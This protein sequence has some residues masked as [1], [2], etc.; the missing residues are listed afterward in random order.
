MKRFLILSFL[1]LLIPT[2]VYGA[3]IVRT[4][5][6]VMISPEQTVEDD[7]YALGENVAIS[8]E[9]KGDVLLA[10]GDITLNGQAGADTLILAGL[11]DIHGQVA[12]DARIV[13]GEVTIAGEILGDLV[14]V[15]SS[16][17]VLPT[18]KIDGDIMF[19]GSKA[20]ISG[21]VGGDIYGFID[22]V[23]VDAKVLGGIEV[24]TSGLVLGDQADIGAGI[25]YT[26][27][28]NLTR[29]QNAKVANEIVRNDPVA[30]AESDNF[31]KSFLIFF[32]ITAFASLVVHLIFNRYT[33]NIVLYARNHTLRSVL[34]GFGIMFLAPIASLILLISTLG[35]IL[36]LILMFVYASLV[37]LSLVMMGI[38]T[39]SFL[40]RFSPTGSVSIGFIVLG[41]FAVNAMFYIPVVGWFVLMG[42]FMLTLGSLSIIT[43]RLFRG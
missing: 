6:M 1:I 37:L 13:A 31:I 29:A 34:I 11:V 2:T 9:V 39:A 38:I 32:L 26:S 22:N 42:L 30:S 25:K 7:F 20:D 16:L 33:R 40:T 14:V 21:E 23:R 12:D 3:S 27:S 4:G 18:A 15:G 36:G 28:N 24:T 41:V 8:G 35:S 5:E 10:G 43:Y 17:K 19:F